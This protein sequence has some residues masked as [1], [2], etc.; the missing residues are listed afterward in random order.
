MAT[1]LGERN[2]PIHNPE[3]A[4]KQKYAKQPQLDNL[5]KCF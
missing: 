1:G 4:L 3:P 5:G 2:N